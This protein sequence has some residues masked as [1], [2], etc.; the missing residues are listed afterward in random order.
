MPSDRS[1]DLATSSGHLSQLPPLHPAGRGSQALVRKV[2]YNLAVMVS[3]YQSRIGQIHSPY[4]ISSFPTEI[5]AF[6]ASTAGAIG[7][8]GARD[9]GYGQNG[10]DAGSDPRAAGAPALCGAHLGSRS[11]A[12]VHRAPLPGGGLPDHQRSR[13]PRPRPSQR[14]SPAE[15]QNRTHPQPVTKACSLPIIS[16]ASRG[17]WC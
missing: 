10:M 14:G 1:A 2:T 7:G 9:P 8:L 6:A 11:R 15:H 13:S 16:T 4:P 12:G 5:Q 3:G 17:W